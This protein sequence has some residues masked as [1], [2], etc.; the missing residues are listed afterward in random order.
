MSASRGFRIWT[1]RSTGLYWTYRTHRTAKVLPDQLDLLDLRDR[2]VLLDTQGL[3]DLRDRKVLRG[4]QDQLDQLGQLGP[5]VQLE[6]QGLDGANSREYIYLDFASI[7][8]LTG[9]VGKCGLDLNTQTP[10]LTNT[11]LI[12]ENDPFDISMGVWFDVLINHVEW[13]RRYSCRHDSKMG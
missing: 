10:G 6:P 8:T 2:K 11:L 3:L 4:I 12:T 9:D 1:T 5:P 7:P 13:K